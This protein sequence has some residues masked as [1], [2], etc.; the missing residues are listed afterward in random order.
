[1]SRK[2]CPN[3]TKLTPEQVKLNKSRADKEYREAN[4]DRV[5]EYLKSYYID[6]SE[7]IKSNSKTRAIINKEAISIYKSEYRTKNLNKLKETSKVWKKENKNS[8]NA[9]NAKRRAAKLRRTPKWA[10]LAAIKQFYLDCP[11]GYEVDHI[12]PLQGVNI[13][14][15]HVL[16]NL[17][18]LTKSEN[19]SKGNK[20]ETSTGRNKIQLT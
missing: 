11:I 18:Y 2:G 8:V 20:F 14:G 13:S 5:K 16:S 3:K 7:T 4:K 1:M 19:S 15:F 10:D 17:Q 9:S 12:I 6:N